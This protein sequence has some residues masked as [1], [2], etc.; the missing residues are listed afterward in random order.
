MHLIGEGRFF[1]KFESQLWIWL[2]SPLSFFSESLSQDEVLCLQ[3]DLANWTLY[4]QQ[5]EAAEIAETAHVNGPTDEET[6]TLDRLD[7]YLAGLLAGSESSASNTLSTDAQIV[8]STQNSRQ[9][10]DI[11]KDNTNAASLF[12]E[13]HHHEQ[14]HIT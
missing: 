13:P 14:Q 2:S 12:A 5:N 9:N 4:E 7:E 10:S 1:L 6:A 11:Q 3:K 8:S